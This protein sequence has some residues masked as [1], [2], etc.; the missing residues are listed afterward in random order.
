MEEAGMLQ[1]WFEIFRQT[2]DRWVWHFI[3]LRDGRRRVLARSGRD[4]RSRRRA[5]RA[6]RRFTEALRRSQ[7]TFGSGGF[8]LPASSFAVDFDVVPLMAGVSRSGFESPTK[9][10]RDRA[11]QAAP[12]E[13][14]AAAEQP[15]KAE[16]APQA[17]SEPEVAAEAV[18]PTQDKE[19]TPPKSGRGGRRAKGTS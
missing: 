13:D 7:V 14:Q 16:Q 19:T 4:Y 5:L 2:S 18:R 3:E 1:Y 9:R 12:A 11:D 15:V 6:A 17:P 10:R 8:Q